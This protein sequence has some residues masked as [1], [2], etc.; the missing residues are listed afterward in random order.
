MW[1]KLRLAV[2]CAVLGLMVVAFGLAPAA[3]AYAADD[4]VLKID[5]RMRD[6]NN[7]YL[8]LIHI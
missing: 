4:F 8:S 6:E 2:L 5:T 7:M 1:R 3:N